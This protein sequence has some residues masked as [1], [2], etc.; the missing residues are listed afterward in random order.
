MSFQMMTSSHLYALH[1][2]WILVRCTYCMCAVGPSSHL[3][4]YCIANLQHCA[5]NEMSLK[6]IFHFANR[7]MTNLKSPRDLSA[8][9]LPISVPSF[10]RAA[11]SRMRSLL[12]R[13][14]CVRRAKFKFLQLNTHH[15][16]SKKKRESVYKNKEK[17]RNCE[18]ECFNGCNE[19]R[20]K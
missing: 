19:S 4:I 9:A 7:K 20:K 3:R 18:F 14:H 1:C 10:L 15:V 11:A 8:A 6:R 13:L 2:L 12:Q 16:K 17:R 5:W